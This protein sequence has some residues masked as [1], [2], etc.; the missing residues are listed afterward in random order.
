MNFS[1]ELLYAWEE[2]DY[3]LTFM[4]HGKNILTFSISMFGKP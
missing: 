4:Q 1:S 3:S 2:K